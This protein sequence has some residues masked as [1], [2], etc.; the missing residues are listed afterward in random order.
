MKAIQPADDDVPPPADTGRLWQQ[1]HGELYAFLR[2]R[3]HSE[4][5]AQDLLQ[6]A[7][8]RAHKHLVGGCV[9][10]RPRAWLYQ[11]VRNLAIDA[12]RYTEK[13]KNLRE[14]FA[15][16]PTQTSDSV[17]DEREVFTVVAKALPMFVNSLA[18][19]YQ[20]ALKMT[21]LEGLTQAE[22][23][24]RAGI[25]LSGMKSR[26]Q[27]GRKHLLKALRNCCSFELDARGRMMACSGRA[28][29]DPCCS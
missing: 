15:S 6:A 27:R 9:P 1:F 16:E 20:D 18:P 17:V 3:G 23:A 25:S 10:E 26:V 28:D 12:H 19:A 11:I 29:S 8:L 21:E 24:K 13:Q 7:F 22:A 2:A 5:A 14:A 4:D